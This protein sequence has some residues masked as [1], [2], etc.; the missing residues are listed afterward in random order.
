[1]KRSGYSLW[2]VPDVNSE[3]YHRL[4]RCIAEVAAR[5]RTPT[6]IPHV[7]LLGGLNDHG[8]YGKV[9]K[10]AG[11]LKPYQMRLGEL[12]SDDTYFKILFSKIEQ[13]TAVMHA[14]TLARQLFKVN[15]EAYAPHLSLAY[16]NLSSEQ[17]DVLKDEIARTYYL[18][19]AEFLVREIHLWRTEG[20]VFGWYELEAFP[21]GP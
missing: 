3:L 11:S 1:M 18:P 19:G 12:D 6:F 13:T 8:L 15:E 5:F 7:T 16:G 4:T 14:R 9:E 2:L 17:V 10:L 20:T 21:L